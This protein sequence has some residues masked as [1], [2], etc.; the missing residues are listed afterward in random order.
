MS[1]LLLRLLEAGNSIEPTSR[2]G[3]VIFKFIVMA[4]LSYFQ[5]LNKANWRE[6]ARQQR[7]K[8]NHRGTSCSHDREKMGGV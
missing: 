5:L 8:Y 6:H 7:E 4:N 1:N 2:E 3:A